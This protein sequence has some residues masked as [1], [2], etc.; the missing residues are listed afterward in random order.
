LTD[1]PDRFARTEQ[2]LLG[3]SPTT[4]RLE[5]HRLHRG[6]LILKLEGIEDRSSAEKLRGAQLEV[7]VEDATPLPAGEYYWHQVVGLVVE[8]TRGHPIGTVREILRTGG[9]D[10]YVVWDGAREVLLPAIKDVVRT[11]DLERGLM[12]VD[13]LPGLIS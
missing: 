5:R 9:N 10:V 6:R 11:I 7:P 1:F 13:P 3:S 4:F 2:V 12:V 8:D